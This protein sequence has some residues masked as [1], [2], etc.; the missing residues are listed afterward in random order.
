MVAG[1][2][3]GDDVV[4]FEGEA[5]G[6]LEAV[7]FILE[8]ALHLGEDVFL[9]GELD[10]LAVEGGEDAATNGGGDG[11][12]AFLDFGVS[13]G[14][15]G[16]GG[17]HFGGGNACAGGD[18][19]RIA[20][21]G[22]VTGV[23]DGGQLLE[24]GIV[25]GGAFAVGG[26]FLD[27]GGDSFPAGVSFNELEF[28]VV[29]LEDDVV[30]AFLEEIVVEPGGAGEVAKGLADKLSLGLELFDG[31][32]GVVVGPGGGLGGGLCG[33]RGLGVEGGGEGEEADEREGGGFHG[34]FLVKVRLLGQGQGGG[35]A[36][37]PG[38]VGEKGGGGGV[39]AGGFT[40]V[41]GAA[42]VGGEDEGLGG[43]IAGEGGVVVEEFAGGAVL[44]EAEGGLDGDAGLDVGLDG[45]GGVVDG[46]GGGGG[47]RR[48][49]VE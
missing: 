24:D 19:L 35:G 32:L 5:V 49:A 16:D 6:F 10:E 1:G 37:A 31:G 38:G 45:R 41:E 7:A 46:D 33:G 39:G 4:E 18:Q 2:E 40:G 12:A 43:G 44:G 30:E 15:V 11:F 9:E 20:L 28:V 42:A 48:A 22:T 17:F 27:L 34:R 3:V 36:L 26:E 13:L 14:G 25:G 29:E 47:G 21:G 8:G 23:G